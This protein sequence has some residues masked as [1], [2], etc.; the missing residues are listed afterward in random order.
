MNNQKYIILDFQ[1]HSQ[2][3]SS[4]NE[5]ARIP[6]QNRKCFVVFFEETLPFVHCIYTLGQFDPKHASYAS[7][8]K[9]FSCNFAI[10]HQKYSNKKLIS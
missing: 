2:P 5:D 6:V 10:N 7:N 9:P 8:E 1:S 3:T 4:S